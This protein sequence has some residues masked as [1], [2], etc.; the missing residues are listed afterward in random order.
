MVKESFGHFQV[1]V[2]QWEEEQYGIAAQ[3]ITPA[4]HSK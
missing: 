2:S 3:N 4:P 1:V